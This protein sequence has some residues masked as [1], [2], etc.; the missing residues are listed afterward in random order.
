MFVFL[1]TIGDTRFDYYA[2]IVSN[3]R[4]L[5]GSLW[6]DPKRGPDVRLLG[7]DV[8]RDSDLNVAVRIPL[9]P[10]E[11]GGVPDR[12][13]VVGRH[14]VHRARVPRDVRRPRSRRRHVRAADRNAH[15]HPD[16]DADTDTDTNGDAHHDADALS[17]CGGGHRLRIR[18]GASTPRG[19]AGPWCAPR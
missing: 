10:L 6:R 13:S 16:H 11:I 2:V 1:D 4:H 8:R 9:G 14:D 3:G 15:A 7:L 5:S 18:T 12:L 19:T 17:Q